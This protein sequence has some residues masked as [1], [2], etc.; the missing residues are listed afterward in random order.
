MV[1]LR[2]L[3]SRISKV[4]ISCVLYDAGGEWEGDSNITYWIHGK[5][6]WKVH[7]GALDTSHQCTEG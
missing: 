6:Y 3:H 7:E 4:L 2:D 5:E 1:V